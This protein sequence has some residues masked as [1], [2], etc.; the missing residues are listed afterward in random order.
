[1]WSRGLVTLGPKATVRGTLHAVNVTL[2]PGAHVTSFDHA[3]KLDPPTSLSWTVTFPST[4]RADPVTVRP[5][6]S[7]SIVPGNYGQVQVGPNGTLTLHSGIYYTSSV[8]LA[9]RSSVRIDQEDGPVIVYVKGSAALRGSFTAIQG[10]PNDLLIAY[11]G[12]LPLEIGGPG[13]VPFGGSVVAPF[14]QL[15]IFPG[16]GVHKGF[17]AAH[18]IVVGPGA[19]LDYAPP[20]AVVG[21]AT[22]AGDVIDCVKLLPPPA[23]LTGNALEVAYQAEIARYCTMPGTPSCITSLVGRANY[24]YSTAAQ[25]LVSQVFSPAQYLALS[26]DR[27]RKLRS[28]EATRAVAQAFCNGPD[29]DNDWIPDGQDACPGTPLL[30]A[31]DD[32]GCPTPLPIAP[33]AADVQKVINAMGMIYNPRCANATPPVEVSHA[34]LYQLANPSNGTFISAMRVTNQPSG[35][36]VWYH[37]QLRPLLHGVPVGP[38]YSVAFMETEAMSPVAGISGLP[39]VPPNVIQFNALPTDPGT[40]GV[41]G[42]NPLTPDRVSFHVQAINAN[43]VAGPWSEW[44][45]TAQSDCRSLGIT[46]VIRN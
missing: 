18:D 11:L 10:G 37:F 9:P 41:L 44:K 21:A 36:P 23:G 14:A 19:Q 40:R 35:C 43:G 1:M 28:A 45:L 17:F 7:Q 4:P 32:R 8:E 22:A 20:L 12:I 46:C 2:S 6:Q 30:V 33:G 34:A 27:T 3:P 29:S 15:S 13:I 42:R 25:R 31:T 5:G 24:D 39:E 16:T 26:R 38:P